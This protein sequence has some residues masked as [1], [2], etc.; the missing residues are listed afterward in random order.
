MVSHTDY[1]CIFYIGCSVGSTGRLRLKEV[2]TVLIK[3]LLN[4]ISE[5]TKS[6]LFVLS[7]FFTLLFGLLIYKVFVLQVIEGKKLS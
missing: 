1:C 3:K 5:L 6:R 7:A 4:Y 2:K